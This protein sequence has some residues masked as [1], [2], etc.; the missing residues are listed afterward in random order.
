MKQKTVRFYEEV[1]ADISAL[2]ALNDC[3]KYGFNTAR[4]MIITAVNNYVQ[5][6]EFHSITLEEKDINILADKIAMRI[7]STSRS[8]DTG[9]KEEKYENSTEN[10]ETYQKAL[11][12]MASL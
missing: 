5:E 9:F 8:Y 7:R 1:P 3:K 4:E 6:S 11:S 2:Q 12:F 10:N